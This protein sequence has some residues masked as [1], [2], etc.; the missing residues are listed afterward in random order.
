MEWEDDENVLRHRV[1]RMRTLLRF[2]MGAIRGAIG[3]R[4]CRRLGELMRAASPSTL[5]GCR[6]SWGTNE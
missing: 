1:R 5:R 2:T 4:G 6:V 3:D